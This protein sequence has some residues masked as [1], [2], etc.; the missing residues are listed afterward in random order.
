MAEACTHTSLLEKTAAVLFYVSFGVWLTYLFFAAGTFYGVYFT[1]DM[2]LAIRVF[3]GLLLLAG[4]LLEHKWTWRTLGALAITG[5]LAYCCTRANLVNAFDAIV[6]IFFGRNRDFKIAARIALCCFVFGLVVT[7][8][9]A[10]LGIIENHITES[11]TRTRDYLGFRYP[12]RPQMYLFIVTCLII[13]LAQEKF[14]LVLAGLLIVANV[15]MFSF[16]GSRLSCSFAVMVVI[17]GFIFRKRQNAAPISVSLV[18]ASSFFVAALIGFTTALLYDPGVAWMV[19]L[20]TFFGERLRLAHDGIQDFGIS[21][22]GQRV[23]MVGGGL[24]V[25]GNPKQGTY[26]YVDCVY[27]QLAIL[28]GVVYLACYLAAMSV[29]TY[30]AFRKGD[31]LLG[32]IFVAFAFHGIIDNATMYLHYNVFLL[33][34]APLLSEY[35]YEKALKLDG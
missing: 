21:L 14:N 1:S 24:D 2:R 31:V 28:L 23:N 17:A 9:S 32:I 15:L 10:K 12:L 20:N 34:C 5:I 26:N 7:I 29:T 22:F 33:A 25:Y 30:R 4:E 6:I 35:Q 19:D 16:T 13:Y 27:I 18:L 11:A 3:C 8:L